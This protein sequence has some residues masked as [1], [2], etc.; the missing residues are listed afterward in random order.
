RKRGRRVKD[1]K[2]GGASPLR[3]SASAEH[4]E[5]LLEA[6]QRFILDL[7]GAEPRQASEAWLSQTDIR[8][9]DMRE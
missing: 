6:A 1:R 2:R 9:A 4:G 3:T 5:T 7:A 8:S